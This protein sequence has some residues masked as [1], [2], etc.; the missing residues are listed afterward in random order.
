MT[1]IAPVSNDNL[2]NRVTT[3]LTGDCGLAPLRPACESL[4]PQALEAE[5]GALISIKKALWRRKSWRK[6]LFSSEK[7]NYPGQ[8]VH[9][10]RS[11]FARVLVNPF[12]TEGSPGSRQ[13]V[14]YFD[15]RAM[16]FSRLLVT[17]FMI[18][19]PWEVASMVT[20]FTS[21]GSLNS[22]NGTL[23]S[24]INVRHYRYEH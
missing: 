16:K 2:V 4:P 7:I 20:P 5:S 18:A 10:L 13:F 19:V 23:P 11:L 6:S 1:P 22:R 12:T 14:R 17:R 21:T 9:E 3:T 24:V 8:S 15:P